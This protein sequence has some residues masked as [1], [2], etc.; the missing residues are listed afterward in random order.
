MQPQ[1]YFTGAEAADFLPQQTSS[2]LK[3]GRLAARLHIPVVGLGPHEGFV[4]PRT[5]GWSKHEMA[6][7]GLKRRTRLPLPSQPAQSKTGLH[8]QGR[9]FVLRLGD[10]P[11]HVEATWAFSTAAMMVVDLDPR[12]DAG[13]RTPRPRGK[14]AMTDPCNG[15]HWWNLVYRPL[16]RELK[17]IRLLTV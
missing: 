12:D 11:A 14:R 16:D 1:A 8:H 5:C 13:F 2:I 6:F 9:P 3:P 15:E 10:L 4:Q 17:E 7:T